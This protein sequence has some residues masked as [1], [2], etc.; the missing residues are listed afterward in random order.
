MPST[1][2][3]DYTATQ[4]PSAKPGPGIR[5]QRRFPIGHRAAERRQRRA[6]GKV[7]ADFLAYHAFPGLGHVPRALGHRRRRR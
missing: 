2:I 3:G 7:P 6:D 4:S 1:Y 5:P